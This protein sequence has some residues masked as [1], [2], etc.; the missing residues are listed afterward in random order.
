MT[1]SVS[2]KAPAV[3]LPVKAKD[4]GKAMPAKAPAK[5]AKASPSAVASKPT[6]KPPAKTMRVKAPAQSAKPSK[7][8]KPAVVKKPKLV[9][10]S[11]TLPQADHDLIKLC[12]KTAVSAGRETKK[13]EVVRAAIQ[14]FAAL[15]GAQQLA[16][17]AKLQAIALGRPKAK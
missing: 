17:Y 16:A 9:R 2:A 14:N 6:A 10:D 11:F 5:S 12:K 8:A 13:S 4:A 3:K 15:S 1:T 7:P